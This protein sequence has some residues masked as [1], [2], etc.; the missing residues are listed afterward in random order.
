[1][2]VAIA[3]GSNLGDRRAHLG[4]AVREL[5]RIIRHLTVS[6]LLETKP[7]GEGLEHDPDFLNAVAV[8]ECDLPPAALVRALLDMEGRCGRRRPY[9]NAPRT[10]DLDLILADD[11]VV[12]EPGVQVPHPRFRERQFVLEPLASVAPAMIDPLTGLTAAELLERLQTRRGAREG[13]S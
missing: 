6:E 3:L 1:M 10:L 13:A 7:V 4:W 9:P 5:S 2:R 8:G 12:D 11:L